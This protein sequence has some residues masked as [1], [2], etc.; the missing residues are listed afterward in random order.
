MSVQRFTLFAG[1]GFL[2]VGILG[3]VPALVSHPTY[4]DVPVEFTAFHG[5]LFGIFPV[6]AIHNIV[7]IAF[8][9]WALMAY[10]SFSSSRIFCKANAV[11]YGVLVIM[12]F[13]P[14]LNTF[15]GLMPLHGHDIWLHAGIAIAT[16][17]YGFVWQT[18]GPRVAG[19]AARV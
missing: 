14:V 12:G 2:V 6:N 15:F 11:I 9:V 4:S 16:G 8:G 5:R 17:Y 18:A 10:R 19:R 13:I 7:H 3:F 1:I